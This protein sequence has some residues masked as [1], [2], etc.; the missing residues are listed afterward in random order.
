MRRVVVLSLMLIDDAGHV[1]VCCLMVVLVRAERLRPRARRSRVHA[2]HAARLLLATRP[3]EAAL[4]LVAARG[5]HALARQV[6]IARVLGLRA[7]RRPVPQDPVDRRH[8]RGAALHA[9]ALVHEPL[10]YFPRKDGRV[11][12][13]V[14]LDFVDHRGRGHLGLAAPDDRVGAAA[15]MM[16]AARVRAG[17]LVVERT[18]PQR[19]TG[20]VWL[21]V[22]E[23]LLELAA[24]LAQLIELMRCLWVAA[25]RIDE[26]ARGRLLLLS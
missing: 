8:G 23:L 15:R 25:A 3:H 26:G 6:Q 1:V 16:V 7:L 12:A 17:R 11:L 21:R 24:E 4:W 5:Q 2:H 22:A 20:E 9:H 10:S 13:F 18:G 14:L 19:M